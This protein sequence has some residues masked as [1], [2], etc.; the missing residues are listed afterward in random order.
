ME[1]KI[2]E[3]AG[4]DHVISAIH[5]D[6]GTGITYIREDGVRYQVIGTGSDCSVRKGDRIIRTGMEYGQAVMFIMRDAW[7]VADE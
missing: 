7:G 2:G 6:D 1:K 5:G 3:F 4:F